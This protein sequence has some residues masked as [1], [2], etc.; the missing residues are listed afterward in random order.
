MEEIKGTTINYPGEIEGVK[1]LEQR[2]A[3]LEEIVS[4]LANRIHYSSLL[5]E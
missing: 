5:K 1:K 3:K 4:K 2:V